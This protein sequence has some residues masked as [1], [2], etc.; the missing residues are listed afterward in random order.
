[1]LFAGPDNYLHPRNHNLLGG[2]SAEGQAVE[3]ERSLASRQ[4]AGSR[5]RGDQH[6]LSAEW[7]FAFDLHRPQAEH[8]RDQACHAVITHTSGRIAPITSTIGTR[9]PRH[10]HRVLE[11]QRLGQ[12]TRSNTTV[13]SV[14][15]R[16]TAP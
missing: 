12:A 6:D 15:I 3:N 4:R 1:M 16:M 8:S 10:Q 11:R 9:Y 7:I 2:L 14:T 13:S 5:L